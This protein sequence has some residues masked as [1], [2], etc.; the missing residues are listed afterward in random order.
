MAEK[1]FRDQKERLKKATA[2][3][4]SKTLIYQRIK[5]DGTLANFNNSYTNE[6]CSKLTVA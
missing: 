5:A 3:Q 1:M 4:D 2:N 6:C